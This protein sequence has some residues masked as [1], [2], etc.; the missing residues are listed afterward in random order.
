MDTRRW[1]CSCSN[2]IVSAIAS[3]WPRR[4]CLQETC[5]ATG[6]LGLWKTYS[7]K[8]VPTLHCAPPL[9]KEAGCPLHPGSQ[10]QT[11]IWPWGSSRIESHKVSV[12]GCSQRDICWMLR[13]T[14]G[15]VWPWEE[16]TSVPDLHVSRMLVR[17][18]TYVALSLGRSHSFLLLLLHMKE[19]RW[20]TIPSAYSISCTFG[21]VYIGHNVLRWGL[22]SIRTHYFYLILV[23]FMTRIRTSV[24]GS[25]CHYAWQCMSSQLGAYGHKWL[26]Q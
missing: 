10:G 26:K 9:F 1:Q 6:W 7:Y 24:W 4:R 12:T 19:D 14:D 20:L 15:A 8:P 2:W 13:L 22:I 18:V 21:Q 3:N 25:C 11:C 5:W 23:A 17:Y 16:L